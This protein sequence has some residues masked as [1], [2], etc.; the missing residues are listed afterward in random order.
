MSAQPVWQLDMF[1]PPEDVAAMPEAYRY[2]DD[3]PVPCERELL[4]P[5]P[6]IE[7]LGKDLLERLYGDLPRRSRLT[8]I[9]V[10]R[11]MRWGHTHVYDLIIA[12]S[13]DALD[14]RHPQATQN[15]WAI[16]RYSLCR[17]LFNREFVE[18]STR[19]GMPRADLDKCLMLAEKLRTE[20]RNKG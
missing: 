10:C 8:M 19:C 17:F 1:G 3:A 13:L 9:E 7:I 4:W 16:Y 20:K 18:N 11:R 14:G 12:G 2:R 15:A 5:M 6:H